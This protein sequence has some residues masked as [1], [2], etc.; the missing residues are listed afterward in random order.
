MS[1]HEE[2]ILAF[3]A[4]S[5][6][7]APPATHVRGTV[8][9]SSQRALRARD[10][11]DRYVQQLPPEHRDEML[12]MTAAVWLPTDLALVHYRA[13]DA[14]ELDRDQIFAIGSEAGL[15]NIETVLSLLVKLSREVGVTP[16]TAFANTNR[17]LARTWRGGTCAVFKTG[18][19]EF[20]LEWIGQPAASI[21]YF[22]HAFAGFIH[23]ALSLFCRVGYV[24]DLPRYCSSSTLGYRVTWA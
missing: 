11:F 1:P 21:P 14:L 24:R 10:L 2:V 3:E 13:C 8:L 19:K 17:L 12:A 9:L 18:L 5:R 7:K 16:F 6:A 22:R 23:G 4:E 20:R 15:F